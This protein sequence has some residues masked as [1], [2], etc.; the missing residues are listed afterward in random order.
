MSREKDAASGLG[1]PS[2]K[3]EDSG[4]GEHPPIT[5]GLDD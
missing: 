5:T 1:K 4:T 2:Q 3:Y